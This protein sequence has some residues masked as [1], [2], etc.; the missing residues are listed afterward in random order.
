MISLNTHPRLTVTLV[1]Y[2]VTAGLLLSIAL[3]FMSGCGA[4]ATHAKWDG[5]RYSCPAGTD[6]WASESEA[7]AGRDDYTYCVV[8]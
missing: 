4:R 7:L 2:S 3:V 5:Q 8:R 6:L 1:A